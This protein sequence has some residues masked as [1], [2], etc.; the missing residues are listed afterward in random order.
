MNKTILIK[1][2]LIHMVQIIIENQPQNIKECYSALHNLC[3]PML[4]AMLSICEMFA[5]M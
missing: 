4:E 1:F 2:V 5:P 3:K